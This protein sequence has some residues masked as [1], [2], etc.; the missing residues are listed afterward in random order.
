MATSPKLDAQILHRIG[1]E[2]FATGVIRKIA[3]ILDKAEAD[4]ER[5]LLKWLASHDTEAG[6]GAATRRQL[7]KLLAEIKK[8][9]VAA[10]RAMYKG[11][12]KEL[13]DLAKSEG[14]F[15]KTLAATQA[16]IGVKFNVPTSRLLEA[17]VDNKPFQGRLLKTWFDDLSASSQKRISDAVTMGL[18]QGESM[19]QIVKRVSGTKSLSYK[20]GAFAVS[21]R[22]LEAAVRTATASAHNESHEAFA[23]ENPDLFEGVRWITTLDS[24]A[25]LACAELAGEIFPVGEGPRPP[26]HFNCLPGDTLVTTQPITAAA[27]RKFKGQLVVIRTASGFE[28]ACTPN[29]PV[30][31]DRGWLPAQALDETCH[32]LCDLRG[33]SMPTRGNHQ[34]RVARIQDIADPFLVPGGRNTAI[35]PTAAED[36]HGDGTEHEVAIVWTDRFFGDT[37]QAKVC[38]RCREDLFARGQVELRS[39]PFSGESVFETRLQGPFLSFLSADSVMGFLGEGLPLFGGRVFHSEGHG[40]AAASDLNS[41]QLKDPSD[42]YPMNAQIAADLCCAFPGEVFFDDIVFVGR[43]DFHGHVYNLETENHLIVADGITTGNCRCTIETIP[44]GSPVEAEPTYENWLSE[45]DEETQR[46]TLGDARYT[47]W[48]SGGVP[49]GSFSVDGKALTLDELKQRDYAAW[50]R[51]WPEKL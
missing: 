2:R 23:K 16:T 17:A 26:I 45:Q 21:R 14:E 29:H 34:Q 50:V 3:A 11:T 44:V 39:T 43:R 31:T 33:H 48:K 46:D 40:Y 12:R 24:R 37:N 8:I 7:E 6:Y 51:L 4:I 19:D 9:N 13:V 42:G 27:K 35:V 32:V 18:V 49:L 22:M 28:L 41:V 20:D 30:F 47:L 38:Q 36:F 10:H 25:C 5:K 15:A 1:V